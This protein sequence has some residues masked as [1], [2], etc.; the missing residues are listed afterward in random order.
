MIAE[1]GALGWMFDNDNFA[2]GVY[3]RWAFIVSGGRGTG[4]WTCAFVASISK[5]KRLGASAWVD[6]RVPN[7]FQSS[8]REFVRNKALL[9]TIVYFVATA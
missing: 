6:T 4:V 3:Y 2:A 7:V 9:V 5:K 8:V 1:G